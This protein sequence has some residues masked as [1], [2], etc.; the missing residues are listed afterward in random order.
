MGV[1]DL[2][3]INLKSNE[4]KTKT[5]EANF[6]YCFGATGCEEEKNMAASYGPCADLTEPEECFGGE[7]ATRGRTRYSEHGHMRIWRWLGSRPPDLVRW[8]ETDLASLLGR[9]GWMAAGFAGESCGLEVTPTSRL[10][11]TIASGR[12]LNHAHFVDVHVHFSCYMGDKVDNIEVESIRD[13]STQKFN[14]TPRWI[15]SLYLKNT[16]WNVEKSWQKSSCIS[17]DILCGNIKFREKPTFFVCYVKKTKKISR[18]KPY[19]RTKICLFYTGLVKS[20]FSVKRLHEY[21]QC[22][23]VRTKKIIRIFKVSKFS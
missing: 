12:E 9:W 20:R 17:H 3:K 10:R 16:F 2:K 14:S 5:M 18:T 21:I 22:R 13:T 15:C 4:M 11:T 7:L 6:P 1:S 19:C 8:S 23:D